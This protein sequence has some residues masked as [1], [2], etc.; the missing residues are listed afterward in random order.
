MKMFALFCRKFVQNVGWLFGDK[1]GMINHVERGGKRNMKYFTKEWYEGCG[2]TGHPME[3]QVS[4]N[5]ESFSEEYYHDLYLRR[6]RA[7]IKE[8]K[9]A[10]QAD[11][12]KA[13][14]E[15]AFAAA[16]EARIEQLKQELPAEVLEQVADLRVLALGIATKEVRQ[17]LK[18]LK[19]DHTE[20]AVA[21]EAYA[22]YEKSVAE[23]VG[24]ENQKNFQIVGNQIQAVEMKADTLTLKL[25]SAASRKEKITFQEYQILEQEGYIL[26]AEWLAQE[27]HPAEG[28]V[29]YHGLLRKANGALAYL[30]IFAKEMKKA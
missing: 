17:Q 8:E 1:D 6:R 9:E 18:G 16:H 2:E 21:K 27:V 14:A 20:A 23:T 3:L 22:V 30:T 28:G 19:A 5:A 29:E 7:F 26:G 24:K 25:T 15:K 4:K 13:E 10:K 12:E 11:F